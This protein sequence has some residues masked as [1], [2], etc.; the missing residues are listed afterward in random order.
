MWCRCPAGGGGSDGPLSSILLSAIFQPHG[1][2]LSQ[3]ALTGAG[4]E[5]PEHLY[6]IEESLSL[7]NSDVDVSYPGHVLG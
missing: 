6:C 4:V 3:Y 7:F 1:F 5:D 2:A